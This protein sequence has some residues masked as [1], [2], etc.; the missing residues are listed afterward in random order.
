MDIKLENH[1]PILYE[2]KVIGIFKAI[3]EAVIIISIFNVVS[4][5]N[6]LLVNEVN[7]Y[8]TDLEKA[9]ETRDFAVFTIKISTMSHY[10][11]TDPRFIAF[12]KK[13]GLED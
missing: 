11:R 3:N 2:D 6:Q 4:D 7:K 5:Q 12:L 10:F 1:K 8:S 9:Y 13:I